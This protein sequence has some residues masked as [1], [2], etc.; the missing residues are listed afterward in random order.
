M[1][2]LPNGTTAMNT[3]VG[4]LGGVLPAG[5][6]PFATMMPPVLVT[7]DDCGGLLALPFLDDEAGDRQRRQAGRG[8]DRWSWGRRSR[9]RRLL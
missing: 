4:L 9:H 2:W 7:P 1:V 5:S 6:D 8:R 3:I